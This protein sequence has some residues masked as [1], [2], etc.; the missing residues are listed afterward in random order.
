MTY[1]FVKGRIADAVFELCTGPGDV[2]SRLLSANSEIVSLLDN[3]F[4]SE[5][6][7]LWQEIHRMLTKHGPASDADGKISEGA[8]PHTL[9]KIKK[10]TGV[11][12]AEK[13]YKLH[14]E[15]QIRY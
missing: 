6:L 2:R 3:H 1:S 8:I 9:K 13:I 11:Q 15:L 5:L 10:A 7:P 14:K 4:P 12:I